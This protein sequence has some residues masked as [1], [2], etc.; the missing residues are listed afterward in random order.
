[1]KAFKK[2]S[3]AAFAAGLI[4]GCAMLMGGCGVNGDKRIVR[5]AHSQ[6]E[7]HP[8]HLGLLKFKEYVEE[9]LGDKFEVQIYP[10]EL[11]GGQTKVIELAQTGA[12]DFVLVGTP[13]LENFADVYE[14]FSMPYLFT[15]EEA[16]HSVMNDVDYMQ[17]VYRSTD[18]AGFQVLTWYNAGTRSFYSKK[19]VHTPEDL[20]GLKMRV[21]QSPASVN[22]CNAF[23]AAASPM[24]FG[25]VY[26]AIQQGVIDGAENNELA[27]T[28]NKHGEVA[29]YYAYNKHQMV[30]DVLVGN[31]KFLDGLSEEEFEIFQ[32]AALI[33]TEEELTEWEK[34]IEE[35]KE[36]AANDMGVEFIDVDVQLFKDKV[37]DVQADM[38]AEN[39]SI[40]EL[41]DH[42]QQVNEEYQDGSE[43]T[44]KTQEGK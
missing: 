37:A 4:L 26:T 44:K 20:K 30:P 41:Y 1:M 17:Q 2:A 12:I 31:L 35:A 19:P 9:N 29:K 38:L 3:V 25:E 32:E 10:I 6:S 24:S 7:T 40:R 28:N 15:S 39:E 5:I 23:G 18:E 27:L 14:V 22:M 42:I 33:S 21:Q 11:L 16:Y 43:E 13:N 34:Q 8:E 36:T